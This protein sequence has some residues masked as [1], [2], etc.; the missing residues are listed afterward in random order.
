M[1]RRPHPVFLLLLGFVLPTAAPGNPARAEVAQKPAMREELTSPTP[2]PADDHGFVVRGDYADNFS[3]LKAQV[4]DYERDPQNRY[5]YCIRNTATYEC[6]S[7]GSDGAIRKHQLTAV[8]HGTGFAY[9]QEGEDTYLLTNQHVAAWPLVTDAGHKVD[10]VPAGCKLVRQNLKIVDNEDDDYNGDDLPLNTVVS[11]DALDIAVLKARAKLHVLPYHVGH[12]AALN[13]GDVVMVRG[14]PLGAFQAYNTGKVVNTYD[15]DDYKD[16]EHID[17]IIDAPLSSG[18][19][20][21]PV[22]AVSRRTGEYELVGVFHASYTRGAALNAVIGIDQL[23]DVM[24]RLQR[25]QRGGDALLGP[26]AVGRDELAKALAESDFLP[27]LPLGPLTVALR[28]SGPLLVFEIFARGFPLDDRRLAV[29][30]DGPDPADRAAFGR[31]TRVWFGNDRGLKGYEPGGLDADSAGQVE[32]VLRRLRALTMTTLSYR[33]VGQRAATSRDAVAERAA[34]SRVLLRKA[35]GDQDLAQS[36]QD[37]AER[38]G[39]HPSESAESFHLV[40]ADLSAYQPPAPQPSES[41]P[42]QPTES[43]PRPGSS[44]AQAKTPPTASPTSGGPPHGTL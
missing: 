43:A 12:S 11:D 5:T 28:A 41:A 39:P 14:F 13:A 2:A 15:H 10:E 35:A 24:T 37:L 38:L 42:R 40:L 4:R 7:Y 26:G 6:L 9:R 25:P 33:A 30:V 16:W 36:L 29:L 1:P 20:G 3:P 31:L 27:Y 34:L 44:V 23:R 17:F 22:L 21:S 18:N 32:S 8:A 19:S